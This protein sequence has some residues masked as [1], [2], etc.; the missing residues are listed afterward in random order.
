MS[1]RRVVRAIDELIAR[2]TSLLA[3]A[4]RG[5]LIR[6]GPQVAIV[7]APNVGKSSLFNALVGASRAIVN[8]VLARRAISSPRW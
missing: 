4:R 6:E 3:S 7:G 1:I 5:R 2:T 8:D